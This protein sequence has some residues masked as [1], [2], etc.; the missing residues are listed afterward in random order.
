[1]AR[2]PLPAI[3]AAISFIDCINRGDLDGLTELMTDD[4]VLV[5]RDEPPLAGR[6]NNRQAWRGYFTSS[7]NYVI[8]P[9]HIAGDATSVAVLGTTTGS[10]LELP[11]EQEME[12]QVIWSAEVLDG[13]LSLWRVAEDTP[14]LRHQMG[15]PATA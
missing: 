5:V 11:D 7:P 9:R 10:H 12:L 13:R 4:H 15:I 6:S 14:E 2:Q 1:M 8:Y 3:A